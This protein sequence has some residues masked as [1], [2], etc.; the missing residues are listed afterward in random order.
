MLD[1][2]RSSTGE[3]LQASGVDPH[4]VPVGHG[5]PGPAGHDPLEVEL[6]A[7]AAGELICPDCAAPLR[8]RRGPKLLAHFAHRVHNPACSRSSKRDALREAAQTAWCWWLRSKAEV[9]AGPFG[10]WTTTAS[11]LIETAAGRDRVDCRF[12]DPVSGRA[13]DYL[14]LG[15]RVPASVQGFWDGHRRDGGALVRLGLGRHFDAFRGS[16]G[17]GSHEELRDGERLRV[18]VAAAQRWMFEAMLEAAPLFPENTRGANAGAAGPTRGA[19]VS[20]LEPVGDVVTG[21]PADW[22]VVSLRVAEVPEAGAAEAV[23]LVTPLPAMLVR[24]SDGGPLHPGEH[25]RLRRWRAARDRVS[26]EEHAAV[27]AAE[28]RERALRRWRASTR[29]R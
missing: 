22:R 27:R 20:F 3:A 8:F 18:R 17:V 16:V 15:R 19:G 11:A 26:W 4:R 28:E 1:A 6:R 12:A 13:L 2:V 23:V 9:S 24:P 21:R 25:D 10:G 14:F 7:A 29:K 5:E